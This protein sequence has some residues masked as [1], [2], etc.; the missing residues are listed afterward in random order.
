MIEIV[1]DIDTIK[2]T[3][4]LVNIY[5]ISDQ[6]L[7]LKVLKPSSSFESENGGQVNWLATVRLKLVFNHV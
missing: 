7:N 2:L 3:L 4:L 1:G 6:D 5:L